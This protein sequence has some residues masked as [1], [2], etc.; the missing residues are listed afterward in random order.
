M[1]GTNGKEIKGGN[2]LARRKKENSLPAGGQVMRMKQRI[3]QRKEE[4]WA[5]PSWRS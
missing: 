4:A 2:G 3:G 1:E 5:L